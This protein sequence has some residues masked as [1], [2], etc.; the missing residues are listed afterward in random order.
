MKGLKVK[1]KF[2]VSQNTARFWGIGRMPKKR[3]Q[4]LS[5]SEWHYLV[6]IAMIPGITTLAPPNVYE[7]WAFLWPTGWRKSCPPYQC[8]QGNVSDENVFMA[9]KY[10]ALVMY[11]FHFK[12]TVLQVLIHQWLEYGGDSIVQFKGGTELEVRN[13][14]FWFIC[15]V[16]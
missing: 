8:S 5:L 7:L 6:I 12:T 10:C 3:E 11:F 16:N 2:L 9:D 4:Q 14:V 1:K 15:V 13:P